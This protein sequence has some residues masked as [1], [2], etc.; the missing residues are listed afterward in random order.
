MKNYNDFLNGKCLIAHPRIKDDTLSNAIV[1][2]YSQTEDETIGFIIN[3]KVD[4]VF[5]GDLVIQVNISSDKCVNLHRGGNK[6]TSKAFIIHTADYQ[7]N[8][9][10]QVNESYAISSSIDVISDIIRNRGPRKSTVVL[11]YVQW[12]TK[13]LLNDIKDNYWWIVDATDEVLFSNDD[14]HKWSKVMTENL[15]IDLERFP[16]SVGRA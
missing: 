6:D 14:E 11:G 8:D 4:D 3:K 1:F 12:E 10:V 9:S 2:I 13:Q 15:G 7:T 16:S 5:V